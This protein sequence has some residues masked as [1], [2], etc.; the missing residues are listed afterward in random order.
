WQKNRIKLKINHNLS[1]RYTLNLIS[2]SMQFNPK[3][4]VKTTA[5][6]MR[7]LSIW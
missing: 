7:G 3:T 6:S 2:S 5:I 4:P 1:P